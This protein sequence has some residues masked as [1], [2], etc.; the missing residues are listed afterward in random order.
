M[1]LNVKKFIVICSVHF[2]IYQINFKCISLSFYLF[3]T[4]ILPDR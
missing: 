4:T 1:F 2:C 3:N